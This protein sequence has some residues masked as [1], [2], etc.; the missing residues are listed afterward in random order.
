MHRLR[1]LL[2]KLT[3]EERQVRYENMA[4]GLNSIEALIQEAVAQGE[5]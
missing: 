4:D 1:R 5:P 2:K 3:P